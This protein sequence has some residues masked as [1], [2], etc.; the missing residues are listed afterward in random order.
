MQGNYYLSLYHDKQL[1]DNIAD[2]IYKI[3]D[4]KII[5]NFLKKCLMILNLI[6]NINSELFKGN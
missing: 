1:V 4:H 6:P 3:K 2:I 5:K